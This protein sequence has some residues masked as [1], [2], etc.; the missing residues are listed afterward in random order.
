MI[1]QPSCFMPRPKVA[2]AVITL[3]LRNEP[4]V[5]VCDKKLFF[6]LVKCAFGQRRKTLLNT[7][8][9]QGGFDISKEE[10]AA[11]INSAGLDE[12]IRGEAMSIKQ[13]ADL[14]VK[15]FE[16]KK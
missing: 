12:K 15:I 14:T 11:V 7:L 1:V 16:L 10:M 6:K 5:E 4:P 2:S 3:E 8:C 13:F 9:N